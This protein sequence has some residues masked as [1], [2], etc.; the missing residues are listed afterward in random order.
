MDTCYDIV[1]IGAGISGTFAA[2]AAARSG[3]NVL[4]IEQKSLLEMGSDPFAVYMMY[5]DFKS[6]NLQVPFGAT[7][8]KGFVNI[9]GRKIAFD[10][11]YPDESAWFVYLRSDAFIEALHQR[12]Q[13]IPNISLR[14]STQAA[15]LIDDGQRVTGLQLDSGEEISATLCI[16]C[17]GLGGAKSFGFDRCRAWPAKVVKFQKKVK[18]IAT[19]DNGDHGLVHRLKDKSWEFYQKGTFDFYIVHAFGHTVC[20]E[21]QFADNSPAEAKQKFLDLFSNHTVAR[22]LLGDTGLH[23]ASI[24]VHEIDG[25][26]VFQDLCR[27]GLLIG[28]AAMGFDSPAYLSNCSTYYAATT[29]QAAGQS[30]VE[31]IQGNDFRQYLESYQQQWRHGLTSLRRDFDIVNASSDQLDIFGKWINAALEYFDEYYP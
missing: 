16:F 12:I 15:R 23:Q 19:L 1:V 31:C 29:G 7:V 11:A 13:K 17:G 28:G 8:T 18:V 6:L 9:T 3:A 21:G 4:L 5:R 22:E 10:F 30:A 14:Y 25:F 20:C 27:P 24:H 26:G 2:A